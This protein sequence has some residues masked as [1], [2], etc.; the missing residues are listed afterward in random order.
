MKNT[1]NFGIANN[2]DIDSMVNIEKE[3]FSDYTEIKSKI[4]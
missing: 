3:F 1:I 4:N 2:E